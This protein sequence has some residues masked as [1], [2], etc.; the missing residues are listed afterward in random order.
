[1]SLNLLVS[2]LL[3]LCYMASHEAPNICAVSEAEGL[4]RRQSSTRFSGAESLV[5]SRQLLLLITCAL[6]GRSVTFTNVPVKD[7]GY[8]IVIT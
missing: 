2:P 8:Q 1:M 3:C 6:T 5:A 7:V 4:S